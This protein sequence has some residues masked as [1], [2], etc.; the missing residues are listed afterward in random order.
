MYNVYMIRTQIYLPE[1]DH[2]QL[3]AKARAEDTTLAELVRQGVKKIIVKKQ[4]NDLF[5][6]LAKMA[7]PGGDKNLSTNI[8]HY[9][10]EK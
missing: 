8:D 5:D 9:L 4:K 6:F 1:E 7:T 3:V 10:Y 2:K